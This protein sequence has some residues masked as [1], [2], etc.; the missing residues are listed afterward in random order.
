MPSVR[1]LGPVKPEGFG[2]FAFTRCGVRRC[3][4]IDDLVA[5]WQSAAI[6]FWHYV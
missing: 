3:D 2:D 5:A 4:E 6:L 1:F